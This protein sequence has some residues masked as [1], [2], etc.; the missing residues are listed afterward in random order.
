MILDL[1][2]PSMARKSWAVSCYGAAAGLAS[3]YAFQPTSVSLSV[4]LPRAGAASVTGAHWK[5]G[6]PGT[7]CL[8]QTRRRIQNAI[9][10]SLVVAHGSLSCILFGG[11]N[12]LNTTSQADRV[13]SMP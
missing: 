4:D 2:L 5:H 10:T 8:G 1:P 3:L 6:E 13:G 12:L 9:D 7:S 11:R